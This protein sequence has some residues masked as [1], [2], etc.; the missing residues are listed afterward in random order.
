MPNLQLGNY[1]EHARSKRAIQEIIDS[2][3]KAVIL[4]RLKHKEGEWVGYQDLCSE[5]Q[6]LLPNDVHGSF[7]K[8]FER[9]VEL[10]DREKRICKSW[11][12][13]RGGVLV[14]PYEAQFPRVVRE[15]QAT[16]A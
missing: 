11:F 8:D 13:N 3:L 12:A 16:A 5:L 10:L 4:E 15:A 1:T 14:Y 6:D 2:E 7:C 9:V